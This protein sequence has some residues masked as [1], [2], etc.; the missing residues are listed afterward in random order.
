M[1]FAEGMLYDSYMLVS[2]GALKKI[3]NVPKVFFLILHA[4]IVQEDLI[5]K[6]V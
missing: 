3:R 6:E 1:V 5:V 2:L 4:I